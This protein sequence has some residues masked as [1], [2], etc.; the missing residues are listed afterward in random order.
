[1]VTIGDHTTLNAGSV[2][3]SHSQEDGGFKRDRIVI[4]AGCT[5]GANALV[6]YGATVGD[7]AQLAPGAFL[8]KGAEVPADTRWQHNP[9]QQV[10][11]DEFVH[12]A[13][14]VAKR[15]RSLGDSVSDEMEV[16]QLA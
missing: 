12:A 15:I 3:Q 16:K 5:I 8:M 4:G 14:R 1:M 9:A 2:V 10:D 6:H 7:G 11:G 13:M